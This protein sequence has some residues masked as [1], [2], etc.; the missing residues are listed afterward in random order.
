MKGT[1]NTGSTAARQRDDPNAWALVFS[2]HRLKTA[3]SNCLLIAACP[4]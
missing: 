3:K 4:M 1:G 2:H